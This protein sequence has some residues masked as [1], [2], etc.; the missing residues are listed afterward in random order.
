MVEFRSDQRISLA[1]E[2]VAGKSFHPGPHLAPV[3]DQLLVLDFDVYLPRSDFRPGHIRVGE[4]FIQIRMTRVILQLPR[5]LEPRCRFG[6]YI[7]PHQL[8]QSQIGILEPR[9]RVDQLRLF[10]RERDLG[11]AHIQCAHDSSRQPFSLRLELL[12]ENAD[13][14]LPHANLRAIEQQLVK[15]EPHIHRDAIHERLIFER[16]LLLDSIARS[17]VGWRSHRPCKDSAP[18]APRRHNPR[19]AGVTLPGFPFLRANPVE[20]TDGR[21]PERASMTVPRAASNCLAAI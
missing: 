5:D 11:P 18:R 4:A 16:P 1:V 9:L 13:R 3:Q 7:D 21:K 2:F 8:A 10:V 19:D 6:T 14:L 15:G 17:R 12:L 20:T